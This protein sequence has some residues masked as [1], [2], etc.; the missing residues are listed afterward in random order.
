[1]LITGFLSEDCADPV[2][3]SAKTSPQGLVFYQGMCSCRILITG[4]LSEDCANPV[5]VYY[6]SN[7]GFSSW[8]LCLH[9]TQAQV[10][11]QVRERTLCTAGLARK[12]MVAYWLP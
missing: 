9:L 6:G 10:A 12:V 3:A 4:F 2:D 7:C 5:A 1:M 8:L 11:G